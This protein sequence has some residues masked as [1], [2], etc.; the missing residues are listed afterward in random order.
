M[1][2]E[3]HCLAVAA[4]Q[5]APIESGAAVFPG[6]SPASPTTASPPVCTELPSGPD[7]IL[8]QAVERKPGV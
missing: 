5:I 3:C 2:L 4:R 6:A 1:R 7:S 8:L